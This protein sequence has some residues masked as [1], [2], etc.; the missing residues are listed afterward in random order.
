MNRWK[1]ALRVEQR[2]QQII[3][4]QELN[5]V[6]FNVQKARFLYFSIEEKCLRIERDIKPLL[7][8][9]VV[10]NRITVSKPFKQTGGFIKRV[11]DV[12]PDAEGLVL[13]PFSPVL[14]ETPNMGSRDQMADQLIHLGWKPTEFT[15][16]GRPKITDKG[17]PVDTLSELTGLAGDIA[18]WYTLKHRQS[19]VKGLIK[20]VRKDGRV[21]AKANTMGTPTFRFT[22]STVV[23]IPKADPSVPLG[24]EMRSLF[25]ANPPKTILVGYD[26]KGLE[27]RME[28][29]YTYPYDKGEYARELLEGD[30]H[31]KNCY[32][33]YGDVIKSH[34]IIK[35]SPEFKSYRSKSKNGKYALTYGCSAPKLAETLGVPLSQARKLWDKY[36]EENYSLGRL[37]DDIIKTVQSR[38]P[39]YIYGIDG[40]K[41]WVRSE[42]S[43][44]NLL[45]QSAGSICMKY[46]MCTI[47]QKLIKEGIKSKVLKVLDFHDEGQL[48]VVNDPLVIDKVK[49][50]VVESFSEVTEL[51]KLNVPLEADISVGRNW[52]ETH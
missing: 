43:A 9:I 15:D 41:L 7:R 31:S 45:F 19:Q 38:S 40:R 12:I 3:T 18:K 42:H 22:H 16:T 26:A 32:I 14:F 4:E 13:G 52:S 33:F 46:I 17:K 36:W 2:V 44:L 21:T 27:A 51:L 20:N 47:D 25:K 34:G 50:I 28:A 48:E 10:K 11:L 5:G 37:R 30:P 24:K 49:R 23:N 1:R 8:P 39:S 29:H 35:D 6:G